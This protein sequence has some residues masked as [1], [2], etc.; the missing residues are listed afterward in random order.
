ML[1]CPYEMT[2]KTCLGHIFHTLERYL[3]S[4]LFLAAMALPIPYD[5]ASV[6]HLKLPSAK[7]GPSIAQYFYPFC[8]VLQVLFLR[9][10]LFQME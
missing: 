3:A 5:C 6:L 2:D 9:N 7:I 4:Y 8:F 10:F 1:V